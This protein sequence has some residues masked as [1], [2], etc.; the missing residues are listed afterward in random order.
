MTY[1]QRHSGQKPEGEERVN[2]P[3]HLIIG[4]AAFGKPASRAVTWCALLGAFLPDLSL[5]AMAGVSLFLLGISPE[6]VF[7][8]LYY[9]DAW[10]QVFAIDNSFIL[11]GIAFGL[12]WWRGIGWAFALC[13]AALIHLAL[14]FPLHNHDA[15]MHFWPVSTWKFISPFSYWESSRGG[16]IV[17]MFEVALVAVL[18]TYLVARFRD[19]WLRVAFVVLALLQIAPFVV[20]R[21]VF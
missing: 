9:S 7:G 13:G 18:A 8:Q 4:A 2:T 19:I 10:Q 16:N 21:L 1:S 6:V 14:D 3:A 5:Y 20:W 11:W 17:G 12:A 15:R